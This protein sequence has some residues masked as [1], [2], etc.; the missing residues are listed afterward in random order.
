[1]QKETIKIVVD[2]NQPPRIRQKLQRLGCEVE[3][4]YTNEKGG[5]YILN[6]G[7]VS[8]ER[9]RVR[10]FFVN[11]THQYSPDNVLLNIYDRLTKIK[12]NY[13]TIILL[14]EGEN[15]TW[16]GEE[17]IIVENKRFPIH[18]HTML[19]TLIGVMVWCVRNKVHVVHTRNMDETARL[20]YAL[21]KE[22]PKQ[23]KITPR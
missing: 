6:K 2:T 14:I 15:P 4:A 22:L 18:R 8:I 13:E 21:A 17:T 7:K 5:H 11:I 1:M 19:G 9:E 20:I 16:D 12:K 10:E 23:S 3:T